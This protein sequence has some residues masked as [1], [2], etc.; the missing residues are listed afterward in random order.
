MQEAR[1]VDSQLQL[2]AGCVDESSFLDAMRAE[3]ERYAVI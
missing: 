3:A 2:A 1:D